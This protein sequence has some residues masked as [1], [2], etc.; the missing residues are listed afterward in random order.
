MAASF[1]LAWT[2]TT[3]IFL[4]PPA[5]GQILLAEGVRHFS[6]A[7]EQTRT[8]LWISGALMALA[9]AVAL[10]FSGLVTLVY[11]PAYR[12]AA[13]LWSVLMLGSV[14]WAVTSSELSLARVRGDQ[15]SIIAVTFTLGASVLG[16]A[17][18]LTPMGAADGAAAAW[19]A[20]QTIA[21]AV[22]VVMGRRASRRTTRLSLQ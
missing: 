5:I 19:V 4:V 2:L 11:G 6:T 16:L 21:A 10:V 15:L 20:G 12:S 17:V 22:A 9:T 3:T 7:R 18:A 14:P 13:A 8:A 1:Y